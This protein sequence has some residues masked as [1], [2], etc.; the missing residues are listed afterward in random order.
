MVSVAL[1]IPGLLVV[2]GVAM[3][4]AMDYLMQIASF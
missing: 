1:I 3:A 2:S 4:N